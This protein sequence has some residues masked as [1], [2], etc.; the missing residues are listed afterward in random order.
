MGWEI[1]EGIIVAFA[2]YAVAVP[3]ALLWYVWDL[4]ATVDRLTRE[5]A[6]LRVDRVATIAADLAHVRR[7]VDSLSGG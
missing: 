1:G 4:R 2:V 3:G 5:N 6:A 7:R